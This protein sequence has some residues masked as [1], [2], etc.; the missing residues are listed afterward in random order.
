MNS[1]YFLDLL[2]KPNRFAES[3]FNELI[4]LGNKYP[5][6][7]IIH[8]LIAKKSE[9]SSPDDY[10][11]FLAKAA[12]YSLDRKKLFYIINRETS[13]GTIEDEDIAIQETPI[14]VSENIISEEK[15]KA[16]IG[17]E[18][19]EIISENIVSENSEEAEI[20]H[21][22]EIKDKKEKKKKKHKKKE[23]EEEV[24]ALLSLDA[25]F[26]FTEWLKY[27]NKHQRSPQW[28]L[29]ENYAAAQYEAEIMQENII[30]EEKKKQELPSSPAVWKKNNDKETEVIISDLAERSIRK[31][32][33]TITETFAKILDLQKKY[34]QAID[35]YEKLSLKY[36]E[37]ST[38]FALR[39]EELKKKI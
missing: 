3:N 32:E 2:K 26:S 1:K 15:V 36:P 7:S 10:E 12:I 34:P 33:S 25:K 35:A 6:T 31:D 5:Y 20:E 19:T 9:D 27:L 22:V 14:S 17:K 28:K 24:V 16:S 8:T 29:E 4:D 21:V 11:S 38:F 39:I 18:K 23:E 30:E 37:K 13:V